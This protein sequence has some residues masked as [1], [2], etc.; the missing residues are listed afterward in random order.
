MCFIPRHKLYHGGRRIPT[1][2]H[3]QMYSDRWPPPLLGS[4]ATKPRRYPPPPPPYPYHER[5]RQNRPR[6]TTNQ[7]RM[8][9]SGKNGKKKG[10]NPNPNPHGCGHHPTT[11][12]P[13]AGAANLAL[14]A[15]PR[16]TPSWYA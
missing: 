11:G 5:R 4:S 13:A 15:M 9:S 8:N 3:D 16:A 7:N 6:I 14:S 1:R 2:E 12:T 10:K